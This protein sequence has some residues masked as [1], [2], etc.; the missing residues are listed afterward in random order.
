[1]HCASSGEAIIRAELPPGQAGQAWVL[2]ENTGDEAL[3][4]AAER[5]RTDG[6]QV[7]I[8][9]EPAMIEPGTSLRMP[10]S[11][12]IDP[13]TEFGTAFLHQIALAIHHS[14]SG[15]Q[16][17]IIPIRLETIDP[18]ELF[19]QRFEVEPVLGQFL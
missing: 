18:D 12:E 5:T 2:I 16:T 9:S 14:E 13:D 15:N 10:I 17:I 6:S 4:I 3:Q 1:M 7:L 8:E 11:L 19:R